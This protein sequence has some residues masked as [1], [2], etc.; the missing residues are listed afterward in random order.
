MIF[1]KLENLKT[2]G[3]IKPYAEQ[4]VSFIEQVQQKGIAEGR[5]AL[6]GDKLFAIVQSYETKDRGA[7]RMEAHRKYADLQYIVDGEERIYVDF[8]DELETEEDRT[9]KEDIIFYKKRKNYGYHILNKGKFGYYAP[10]DAHMP[11]IKNEENGPVKKIV[12]KI[13][14]AG[15]L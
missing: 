11:C 2:Y 4:I 6:D 8:A 3:D 7:G 10:Q 14:M 1:D 15:S 13:A 5:Y 12:F 9:P